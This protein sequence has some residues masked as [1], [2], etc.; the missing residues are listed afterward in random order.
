MLEIF[1]LG[2]FLSCDRRFEQHASFDHS[3][4][5]GHLNAERSTAERHSDLAVAITLHIQSSYSQYAAEIRR[6][7]KFATRVA[8]LCVV[9]DILYDIVLQPAK[10][11][12]S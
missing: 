2:H 4:F 7:K 6:A 8:H 11:N 1:H 3:I 10:S 5:E 12:L 9:L